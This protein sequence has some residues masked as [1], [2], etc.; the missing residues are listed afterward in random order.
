M[1]RSVRVALTVGLAITAA[2]VGLVLSGSRPT[3]AGTNS[4][5]PER[6]LTSVSG[7]TTVCQPVGTLPAGTKAMRLSLTANAGPRVTVKARSGTQVITH[8]E[9]DAGWGEANTVTVPVKRVPST[10][11]GASVCVTLGPSSEHVLINGAFIPTSANAHTVTPRFRVEYLSAGHRSWW[12]LASSV[13][14]RM[15]LGHAASGT[16][17]VFLLIALMIVV[18]VLASRLLLRELP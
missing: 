2:A 16:W 6:V 3:L 8:G 17:I 5:P 11:T 9:R 1:M 4:V 12:S 18:A 7:G 14:H 10:I 13:A 15:G